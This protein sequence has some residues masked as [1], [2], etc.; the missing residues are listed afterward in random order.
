MMHNKMKATNSWKYLSLTFW[1]CLFYMYNEYYI[2][3]SDSIY[4]TNAPQTKIISKKK[5]Q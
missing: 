3:F 2:A 5:I 1:S 4:I